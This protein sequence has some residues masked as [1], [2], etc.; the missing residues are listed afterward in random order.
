MFDTKDK[1]KLAQ[2]AGRTETK[3]IHNEG[4]VK[5]IRAGQMIRLAETHKGRK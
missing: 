5:L 4:Q 2:R 1:D 3:Y